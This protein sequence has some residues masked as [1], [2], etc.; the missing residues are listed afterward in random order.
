MN[1]P[2]PAET[3]VA[4]AL[5]WIGTPYRHQAS[6]LGAGADCLGLVRGVWRA[7]YGDEA[8]AMPAYGPSWR[9]G[10]GDALEAAARR[11]L[12][13]AGNAPGPGDVV[14]FAMLR[15]R[16]ARHCG[17]MVSAT[18]FVHAQEDVGVTLAELEPGWARRL[19]G[20]FSFPKR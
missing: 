4:E 7:L 13:A 18:R 15:H 17:I 16:A 10:G 20:A 9:D 8:E 11:H 19:A 2:Y 12:I 5:R 3:V 6:T 1:C 14:L